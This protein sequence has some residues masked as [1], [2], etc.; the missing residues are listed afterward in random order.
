MKDGIERSVNEGS[1]WVVYG[2]I[3]SQYFGTGVGNGNGSA[4]GANSLNFCEDLCSNVAGDRGQFQ[5][6]SIRREGH[7]CC[8][9]QSEWSTSL[10]KSV[11]RI[12]TRGRKPLAE[13]TSR[14]GRSPT[15]EEWE[16]RGKR[17]AKED[18]KQLGL[19]R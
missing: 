18:K 2:N 19:H 11:R 10:G 16:K 9:K 5:G 1:Q 8:R 7:L 15:K 12:E 17:K 3:S 13:A 4:S 14:F 6:C